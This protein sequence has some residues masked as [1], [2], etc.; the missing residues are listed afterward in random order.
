[1]ILN[2]K[3]ELEQLLPKAQQVYVA[4]ALIKKGAFS[5]IEGLLPEDCYRKYLI[6]VHLPTDPVI[7]NQFLMA[8]NYRVGRVVL[9][10]TIFH[11]KVYILKIDQ[12]L[13]AFIG[14]ANTT[15][16]GLEKNVE[17]SARVDD[18]NQCNLLVDWFQEVYSTSKPIT[19]QFV[20]DYKKFFDR[21]KQRAY[22]EKADLNDF[23]SKEPLTTNTQVDDNQF[24]KQE[25]FD[26]YQSIYWNDYGDK[27]NEQR[28]K[29]KEKF[30]QLHY[31]IV[32][33]FNEFHLH[34]LHPHYHPQNI[35]S[36]HIYRKNFTN[37]DLA[38]MWLHYGFSKDEL[39]GGSFLNHPR[40]QIILRPNKIGI[41]LVVGK[42]KKGGIAERVRFKKLMQEKEFRELFY[43]KLNELNDDY[44]IQPSDLSGGKY[45]IGNINSS[46][47]L[48]KITRD[49]DYKKYFVIGRDY[50]PNN[51]SFSEENIT[52]KVLTEFSNLYPLYLVFKGNLD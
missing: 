12:K 47:Q 38:S 23:L 18:Q 48:Y 42:D 6:G 31:S 10:S 24:F 27:A 35:V 34:D 13:V 11:P 32:D 17:V 4:S 2:L 44:W 3:K 9:G 26:A 14:S 40:I 43:M 41:W 21:S 5:F 28:K 19:T 33:R 30:K 15:D 39:Q 16:G 22:R 49:D 50:D 1:M 51:L 46:S 20:E 25:H 36:S 29:V 7:L 52:D 8:H 37:K 45:L